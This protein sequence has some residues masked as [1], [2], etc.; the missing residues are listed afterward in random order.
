MDRRFSL[1]WYNGNC[2]DIMRFDT[3]EE[4]LD[5]ADRRWSR[6]TEANRRRYRDRRC[7]GVYMVCDPEGRCIKDYTEEEE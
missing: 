7:G 4:A 6:M 1:E 3:A 5:L 2:G